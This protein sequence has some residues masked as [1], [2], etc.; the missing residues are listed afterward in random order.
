[1]AAAYKDLMQIYPPINLY[2]EKLRKLAKAFGPLWV[3]V[4]GTWATKTYYDLDNAMEGKVPEGYLNTLTREQW[5]GVLDFVKA[6]DAKLMVSVSACPGVYGKNEAPIPPWTPVQTEKLFKFSADY[7]VPISGSEFVNEP[8]TLADTGFP[9]GYTGEDPA[10]LDVFAYHY[11]NGC[12]ERL[13]GVAPDM[14]W[15]AE[16][17]IPKTIL[18]LQSTV[19]KHMLL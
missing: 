13:A 9:E 10:P 17:A 7:G 8:N 12:S 4:S 18:Q 6:V 2:D 16:E 1:M 19:Q 5:I 15:F 14:H 3:R 11:Y